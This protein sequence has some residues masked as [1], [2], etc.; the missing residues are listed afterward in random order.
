MVRINYLKKSITKINA[1]TLKQLKLLKDNEFIDNKLY[2]HL[3]PTDTPAPRFHGQPKIKK[4]EV[5]I[6]PIVSYGGSPLYNLKKYIAKILKAENMKM[7]KMKITTP[8]I[9]PRFPTAS[10]FPLK[11][12]R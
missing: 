11:M 8:R 7:L 1:K 4:L 12:T 5:P 10:F 9:L 6:R 2:Y 3:K